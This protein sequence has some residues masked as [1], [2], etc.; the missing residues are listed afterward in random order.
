MEGDTASA[1]RRDIAPAM[2]RLVVGGAGCNHN[3]YHM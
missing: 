3:A 1:S 2:Y